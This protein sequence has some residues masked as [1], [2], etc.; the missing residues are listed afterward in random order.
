MGPDPCSFYFSYKHLFLI[1]L[2]YSLFF[3]RKEKEGEKIINLDPPLLKDWS[4]E[5]GFEQDDN[6]GGITLYDK[7][8]RSKN[9]SNEQCGYEYMRTWLG[10][11]MDCYASKYIWFFIFFYFFQCFSLIM[12]PFSPLVKVLLLS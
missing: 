10:Q 7:K 11:R 12:M 9:P 4:F 8:Q 5:L 6:G 2:I 3:K 1:W